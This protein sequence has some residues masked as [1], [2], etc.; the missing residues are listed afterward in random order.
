MVFTGWAWARVRLPR[1]AARL[2]ERGRDSS[3]SEGGLGDGVSLTA[4]RSWS[5][6]FGRGKERERESKM[7]RTTMTKAVIVMLD[8]IRMD[9]YWN[10][11]IDGGEEPGQ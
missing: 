7:W 10:G 8:A 3:G 6:V 11:L 1:G 2:E 9:C 4:G 5:A